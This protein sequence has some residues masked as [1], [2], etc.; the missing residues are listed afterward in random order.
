[1]TLRI[2]RDSTLFIL[3]LGRNFI[4]LELVGLALALLFVP[5]FIYVAQ[6]TNQHWIAEMMT[7]QRWQVQKG[8]MIILSIIAMG[9]AAIKTASLFERNKAAFFAK[10]EARR[11]ARRKGGAAAGKKA[12]KKAA[13]NPETKALPPGKPAPAA[14]AQPAPA[15]PPGKAKSK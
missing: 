8:L 11:E 15:L 2:V 4:W 13:P 6:R 3:M 5:V 1:M 7:H 14:K 12:G 9:G 10:E